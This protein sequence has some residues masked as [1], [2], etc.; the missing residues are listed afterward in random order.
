MKTDIRKTKEA[1]VQLAAL[2]SE[3]ERK[4]MVDLKHA[5]LKAEMGRLRQ[6]V[7]EMRQLVPYIVEEV[8]QMRRK[9]AEVNMLLARLMPRTSNGTLKGTEWVLLSSKLRRG[10]ALEDEVAAEN[11]PEDQ[12]HRSGFWN[13]HEVDSRTT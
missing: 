4:E 8:K 6:E 7:K 3:L 11:E 12:Q 2:A 13:Q 5:E 10:T 9:Q 1:A